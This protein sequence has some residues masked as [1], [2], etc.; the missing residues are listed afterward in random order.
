MKMY[1]FFFI[2]DCS[3]IFLT[4]LKTFIHSYFVLRSCDLP[5]TIMQPL[6]YHSLRIASLNDIISVYN[7]KW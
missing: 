2:K 6:T 1:W 7:V 3:Y 5:R 4:K